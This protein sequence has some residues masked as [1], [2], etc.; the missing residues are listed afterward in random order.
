[1]EPSAFF[2]VLCLHRSTPAFWLR[3]WRR[4]S[5]PMACTGR[6]HRRWRNWNSARW[7]GCASGWACPEGWF[8]I[9]Y[10]TASTSSMHAIVCAREMV[11]PEA[12]SDGS[13]GDLVLYTSAQSHNSVE[14]GAIAVGLGQKNVRKV[15]VDAEFRMR[16]DALASM[17]EEDK[18]AGKRPF[19]VVPPWAQRP[20]P[21]SI[22]C[23]RSRTSQ[24]STTCGCMW[25]PRTPA[26]PPSCPNTVTLW[27]VWNERIL[28]SSMP[29]SGYLRH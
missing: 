18:L 4:P 11:A 2:C 17:I 25:T 5:I 20:R 26:L 14:K 6:P 19:C 15:P 3:C 1:V 8:G 16:A 22:R 13:R 21:V 9:V 12:R 10:D 28:W 29:T 24:R 27:P 7:T 23:R